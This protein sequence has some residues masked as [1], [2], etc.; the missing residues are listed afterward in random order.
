[1]VKTAIG[2]IEKLLVQLDQKARNTSMIWNRTAFGQKQS[3]T[4]MTD[5]SPMQPT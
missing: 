1:M 4:V 3:A 2:S 5:S